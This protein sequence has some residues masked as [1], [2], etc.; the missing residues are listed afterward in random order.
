VPTGAVL[1]DLKTPI[2][3]L[4]Q[5]R[6][7]LH[8]LGADLVPRARPLRPI[9]A[10][11]FEMPPMSN[12]AAVIDNSARASRSSSSGRDAARLTNR[13]PAAAGSGQDRAG[14]PKRGE[15]ARSHAAL[16]PGTTGRPGGNRAVQ[17]RSA[18]DVAAVMPSWGVL[19]ARVVQLRH[20]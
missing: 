9:P 16:Q 2:G 13:S 3:T 5:R 7:L 14:H 15:H 20:R 8:L 12:R 10:A 17:L 19:E 11:S 18:A 1:A 4:R 6:D